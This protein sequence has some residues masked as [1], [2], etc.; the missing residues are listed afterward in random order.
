MHVC[1]YMHIYTYVCMSSYM[2]VCV[3]GCGCVYLFERFHRCICKGKTAKIQGIL[4]DIRLYLNSWRG[5]R[6]S[7]V[8]LGIAVNCQMD[9]ISYRYR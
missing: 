2:Y 4:K 3:G 9:H 7:K 6:K 8:N 5:V 1:V